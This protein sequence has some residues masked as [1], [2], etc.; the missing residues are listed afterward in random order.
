MNSGVESKHDHFHGLRWIIRGF[1]RKSRW[2][3]LS[4]WA[5]SSASFQTNF[6]VGRSGPKLP[7]KRP[8]KQSSR[9]CSGV[10]LF[11]NNKNWDYRREYIATTNPRY[12]FKHKMEISSDVY[13][14]SVEIK[15]N[16]R[17]MTPVHTPLPSTIGSLEQTKDWQTLG[18]VQL[19]TGPRKSPP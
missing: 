17:G 4:Q 3:E 8:K 18:N 16:S 2:L 9:Q 12:S 6:S 11:R 13:H 14:L 5:K 10:G 19:Q 1:I 7:P 15:S